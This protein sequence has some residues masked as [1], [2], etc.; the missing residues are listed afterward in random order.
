MTVQQ[1][2][3]VFFASPAQ[4]K[5]IART[6]SMGLI[7][8]V[9]P[10]GSVMVLAGTPGVGKSFVALSWAAAVAHGERWFGRQVQQAPVIYVLGEGWHGFGARVEAWEMINGKTMSDA[11][12]FVNGVPL[13]IDLTNEEQVQRFIAYATPIAPGLIVMDTFLMLAHVSSENDNAEV[14]VVM[15]N[16]N[17]IVAATGATVVLVHHMTKTTGSVRGAS[18]FVGNADTVMTVTADA[19]DDGGFILSTEAKYGG[20]QRN[21]EARTLRGFSVVSPGVLSCDSVVEE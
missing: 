2:Q 4:M 13:G 6:K 8:N 14:A 11:M 5:D 10:S 19:R 20:K 12:H 18:A 1:Q 7:E 3:Q 17:A 21:G 9:V 16:I 15:A